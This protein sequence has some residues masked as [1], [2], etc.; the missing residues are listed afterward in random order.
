[1]NQETGPIFERRAEMAALVLTAIALFIV[2][3]IHLL[4]ALFAGLLVHQLVHLLAPRMFGMARQ[5]QGA[6]IVVVVLLTLVIMTL[7]AL[8]IGGAIAFFRSDHHSLAALMQKMAEIIE[9]SRGTMPQSVQDWLPADSSELKDTVV[10]WLREHAAE[11]KTAGNEVVRGIVYALIGMVIG[12][13]VALREVVSER[14]LGPLGRAI[15]HRAA[16]LADAFGRVVFAQV[17][18]AGLNTLLTAMYLLIG[19][20]LAGVHLPLT[21]SMIALTF[22]AGLLP[23]IGNLISNSVIVVI[24][25][26]HSPAIGLSSLIFLVVVHKLEYFANARIVGTQ[27]NASAWELLV[28]MLVMEAA[29][30][31]PGVVAAPVFYAYAK[32]ELAARG[33][34]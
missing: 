19:L 20:K 4:P 3:G 9:G 32:A 29:F 12:A 33:L 14:K 28:A 25:F 21:K 8:L 24:S 11:V 18:I 7:T 27:I 22:V 1:M 5:P 30:G 34:I 23:I 15:T 10:D 13:L 16:L 2:L 6:K 31:L 17:R 26:S